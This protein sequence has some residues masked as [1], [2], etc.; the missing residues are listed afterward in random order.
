[1]S[2]DYTPTEFVFTTAEWSAFE[3]MPVQGFAHREFLEG[4]V[5]RWLAEHDRQVAARVCGPLL[6]VAYDER[7]MVSVGGQLFIN[8]AVMVSAIQ[9][10]ELSGGTP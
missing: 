9:A 8:Q 2:D 3:L 6:D 4:V 5:T 7:V 1:M 10:A